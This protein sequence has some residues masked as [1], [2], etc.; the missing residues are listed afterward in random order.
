MSKPDIPPVHSHAD[1]LGDD[2]LTA[3]AATRNAR[4][5][6][7]ALAPFVPAHGEALEIAAGTGQHAV[8]C[9]RAFSQL[10]WQPTD[11]ASERLAS[12]DAWAAFE[13]LANVRAARFL[14]AGTPDW[15]H[16]PVALVTLANLMHLIPEAA[17]QNVIAGIA[18][19]LAPGG[20]FFLYGPFREAGGFRS[21]GDRAFHARLAAADPETGYKDR[22]WIEDEALAAGLTQLARIEMPANNLSLV[23]E[24]P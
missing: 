22:E 19:V 4:A 14:D 8:A 5:I 7:E 13:G 3:P 18:R 24:K 23:F 12:I 1:P 9:A 20:R 16:E 6:V 17:V 11:I 21:P 10:N 15:T 2:R